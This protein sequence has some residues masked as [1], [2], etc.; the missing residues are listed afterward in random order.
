MQKGFW[1]LTLGEMILLYRLIQRVNKPLKSHS[2]S[3]SKLF[4]KSLNTSKSPWLQVIAIFIL[5]KKE[6]VSLQQKLSEYKSVHT[7]ERTK[8]FCI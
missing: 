5:E 7:V 4:P 1:A 6:K 2:V 3:P 8:K